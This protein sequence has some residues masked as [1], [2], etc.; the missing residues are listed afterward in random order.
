M[1]TFVFMNL[2]LLLDYRNEKFYQ[3]YMNMMLWVFRNLEI[4]A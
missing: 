2:I 4:F 3:N 1:L